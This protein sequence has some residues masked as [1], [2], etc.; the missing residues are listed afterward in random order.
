MEG[1]L[2]DISGGGRAPVI[3]VDMIDMVS[4]QATVS[5]QGDRK[6]RG[7][8]TLIYTLDTVR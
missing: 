6:E 1:S 5:L 7:M 3:P 4:K 2:G 8:N